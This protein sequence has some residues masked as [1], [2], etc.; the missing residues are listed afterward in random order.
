MFMKEKLSAFV[1]NELTEVEEQRLLTELRSDEEMRATWGRYHVARAA[2]RNELGGFAC[3]DLRRAV[4]EKVAGEPP[5]QASYFRSKTLAKAV[6]G[7]AIAA[8]VATIAI[9]SLRSPV[10]PPATSNSIVQ[11]PAEAT[12]VTQVRD[13][14]GTRVLTTADTLNSYLMEHSEFAPTAGMLPYVRSVNYDNNR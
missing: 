10:A 9:V 13:R 6:S 3:A 14:G 8:S 11:A 12:A 1:D 5:H 2:M 7:L 4:T